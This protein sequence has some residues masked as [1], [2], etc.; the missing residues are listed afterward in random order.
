MSQQCVQ[1]A[2]K[3]NGI[4]AFIRN[5]VAS[6]S[7]EVILPLYSALR[8][9]KNYVRQS[10][11]LVWVLFNIFI[12]NTE[13]EIERT[14]CKSAVDMKLSS[15]VDTT[16]GWDAIQGNLRKM[17]KW[18]HKNFMKFNKFKCCASPGSGESQM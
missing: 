3:A 11:V 10:S 7:R 6:R 4:L 12:N 2:K 15:S 18:A 14:L 16:E 8:L 9:V 1:V 5:G 13:S 17:E